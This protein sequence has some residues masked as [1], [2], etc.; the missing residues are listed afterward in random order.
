MITLNHN[1][2]QYKIIEIT[3][4]IFSIT[5]EVVDNGLCFDCEGNMKFF[6]DKKENKYYEEKYCD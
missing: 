5:S 2:K 1:K 6:Y 3:T 4:A